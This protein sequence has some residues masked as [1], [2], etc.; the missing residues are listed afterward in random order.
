MADRWPG[1][2]H[3]AL[4]AFAD[5]STAAGGVVI[6]VIAQ[7]PT[8]VSYTVRCDAE[9]KVRSVDMEIHGAERLSV[10]SDR[11]GGWTTPAGKPI[12]DLTG[13][14]DVDIRVTPYTKSLPIRR[15]G[16]QPG[17]SR[18]VRVAVIDVPGLAIAPA[19]QTYTCLD[20]VRRGWHLPVRVRWCP[21]RPRRRQRRARGELS[22]G[23]APRGLW[24]LTGDPRSRRHAPS[25]A[26]GCGCMWI[27]VAP[28]VPVAAEARGVQR[29]GP[30]STSTPSVSIRRVEAAAISAIAPSNASALRTD[31]LL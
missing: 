15:L 16:L 1:S 26:C 20:L 10:T 28:P 12:P 14:I 17:E 4:H 30:T 18:D 13:C 29:S 9:W 2:E 27:A 8:R 24:V 31:G 11:R 19:T 5:G 6:G 23:L 22:R 7:K 3:L 21:R 25:C